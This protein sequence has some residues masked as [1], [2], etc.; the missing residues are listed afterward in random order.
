MSWVI[1]VKSKSID[2]LFN[3]LPSIAYNYILAFFP[4]NIFEG[5]NAKI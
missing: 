5:N 2:L 1:N 4:L 3:M